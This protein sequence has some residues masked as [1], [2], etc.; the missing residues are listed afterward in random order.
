MSGR[1]GFASKPL[2]TVSGNQ[3]IG[4]DVWAGVGAS[5][6]SFHASGNFPAT[7]SGDIEQVVGHILAPLG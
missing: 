7:A 4:L 5:D 2:G 6:R 3:L 1:A